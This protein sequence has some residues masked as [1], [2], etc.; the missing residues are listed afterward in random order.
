LSGII[1]LLGRL[2]RLKS[3]KKRQKALCSE[4]SSEILNP[5][6]AEAEAVYIFILAVQHRGEKAGLPT[7][8]APKRK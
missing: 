7:D 3:A 8:H 1:P 6:E 4:A 5:S 2:P